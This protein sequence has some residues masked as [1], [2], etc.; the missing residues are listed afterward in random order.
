MTITFSRDYRWDGDH[1]GM[2]F[3]AYVDGKRILCLISGEALQDYF[4]A[5]GRHEAM[6]EAFLRNRGLIESI[7][8]ALIETGR[9]E[10][11]GKV[12]IRGA[13]VAACA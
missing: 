3:P 4:G 6:E 1:Y 8:H 7:A 9:L 5:S 13:D 11:S 2:A 10:E 12:L